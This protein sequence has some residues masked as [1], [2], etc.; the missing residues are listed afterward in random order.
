MLTKQEAIKII[1]D[2]DIN[3]YRVLDNY[4]KSKHKI[5]GKTTDRHKPNNTLVNNFSKYITDVNVGYLVGKPVNYTAIEEQE[6][7]MEEIQDIFTFNDEQ[8]E[9]SIIAKQASIK[10]KAFELL[11][12]D[13][14]AN[15]R[16][17]CVTPENMIILYDDSITPNYKHA[18]RFNKGFTDVNNNTENDDEIT[19]MEIYDEQSVDRYESIN[20]QLT[21]TESINHPFGDV[22]VVE[23]KNND[24]TMG[25]FE[26]VLS[27]ID[28]YNKSQSETADDIEYFADAY[29]VIKNMSGTTDED[30]SGMRK[31]RAILIDEDGDASFLTKSF[32]DTALENYKNR[33]EDDIHKFSMTPNLTDEAFAGNISGIALQFKLWGLEQI[34]AQK[35]RLFKKGLQRRFE[36]IAN[37]FTLH[38]KEFLW[39]EVDIVFTRNIPMNVG[40][41]VEMVV[42]L[43]GIIS[44]QT[45][46]SQLPYIDDV[47]RELQ[48]LENEAVGSVDL[49]LPDLDE[50]EIVETPKPKSQPTPELGEIVENADNTRQ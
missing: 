31:N 22:P 20:G 43:R 7:I 38:K 40:D 6:D 50:E 29:L 16:F 35:E 5:L 26:T 39:R 18:I 37:Y 44:D 15:V 14:N 36:L 30:L 2:Y 45:L 13:E 27:L 9:N 11:Y 3:D 32:N 10:G 46:L 23:F 42:K 33:V 25:D 24:E 49:S 47:T 21:L 8:A 34:A 19:F 28:A 48:Q 41:I 1:E 12:L 4:Y 17:N